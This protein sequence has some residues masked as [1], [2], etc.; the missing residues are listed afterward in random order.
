MAKITP[1]SEIYHLLNGI[2]RFYEY[3]CTSPEMITDPLQK[4]LICIH[5]GQ[6]LNGSNHGFVVTLGMI[7]NNVNLCYW[8]QASSY[9]KSVYVNEDDMGA[10]ILD[11]SFFT[12]K[13][14]NPNEVTLSHNITDSE[15]LQYRKNYI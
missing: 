3:T 4:S 1:V 13:T 10:E 7:K 8:Q 12:L 15:M 6:M 14:L 11:G 5:E 9:G 2:C